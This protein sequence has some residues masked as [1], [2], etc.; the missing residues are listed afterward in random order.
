MEA[1]TRSLREDGVAERRLFEE[2]LRQVTVS[3]ERQRLELVEQKRQYE[4][5]R[6][7]KL[8]AAQKLPTRHR[9]WRGAHPVLAVSELAC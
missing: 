8:T 3:E 5:K 7:L 2:R 9:V 1:E 6:T 4:Q